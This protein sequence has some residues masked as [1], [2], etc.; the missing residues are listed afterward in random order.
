MNGITQSGKKQDNDG[1]ILTG[2]F[3]G[4]VTGLK[5]QT[6]TMAGLTNERGEFSYRDGEAVTFLV[7][8]LAL[9]TTD[10]GPRVNLA[11]LVHRVAGEH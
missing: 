6:P 9:G 10:G 8:R 2:V 11:Q 5:Y 4:P 3:A 1:G 7:G